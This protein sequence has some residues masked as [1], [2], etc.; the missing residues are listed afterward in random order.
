VTIREWLQARVPT[1]P[2]P[3]LARLLDVVGGDLERNVTN[4]PDVLLAA[5]ERLIASLMATGATSRDSA[6]DLL[7]ADS[8][9]TYAFEAASGDSSRITALARGSM[10]R[11]A[12]L[13]P[14]ST[15]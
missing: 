8:L 14:T 7:V 9:V 5:S 11:I 12:A 6:L 3:L 1:P 2:A 4:A 10:H 15:A 13:A